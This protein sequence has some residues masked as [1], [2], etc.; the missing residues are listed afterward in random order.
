MKNIKY[1]YNDGGR[2]AA[3][4]S[5]YAGDCVV[6]AIA[7][8]T[9]ACYLEVY[10]FVN[11]MCKGKP[12]SFYGVDKK[13]CSKILRHLGAKW[14]A[15]CKLPTKGKYVLNMH[16]HLAALVDGTVQDT[17]ESLAAHKLYGYWKMPS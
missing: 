2:R 12:L 14:V 15:G 10:E 16:G 8:V 6:R 1:Q 11:R 4:Y 5:P 13:I 7:I 9:G 17:Y 3:G